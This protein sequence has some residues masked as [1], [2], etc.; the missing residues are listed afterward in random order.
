MWLSRTVIVILCTVLSAS[1]FK[2]ARAYSAILAYAVA[3]LGSILVN[4]LP[5]EN[6]IGLLFSY[7]ICGKPP[8]SIFPRSAASCTLPPLPARPQ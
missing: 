2:N 7:W 3:I 4:T 1:Y 8:P 6:R 5:S